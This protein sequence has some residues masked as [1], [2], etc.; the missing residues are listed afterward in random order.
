MVSAARNGLESGIIQVV[1]RMMQVRTRL[2]VDFNF[3]GS[4]YVA[5]LGHIKDIRLPLIT[6]LPPPRNQVRVGD[7]MFNG[8]EVCLSIGETFD[9]GFVFV[10]QIVN[11]SCGSAWVRPAQ[12]E[13]H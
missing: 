2:I 10:D 9:G 3:K 8:G 12:W 7:G 5:M 11:C 1:G 6:L 4:I 13:E